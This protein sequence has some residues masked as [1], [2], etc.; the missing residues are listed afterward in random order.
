MPFYKKIKKISLRIAVLLTALLLYLQALTLPTLAEEGSTPSLSAGSAILIEAESGKV[1]FEK[2]AD[3]VRPMASTTKIMTALVALES[4]DVQRTV[5]VSAEAIGIEGSS[6]YLYKDE[7]LTLE[8]L[9]YAM[10]LESAND[11]A[12]AIAI[13]VGGSIDEFADMMNKKADE[14]GLE[15]THFENPHGLDC[16]SHYTTARELAKIAHEAM[17]N[18]SFRSIVS[19]FKKTI[20]LNESEGVR[21]LINHNKMLKGYDGAVGIKTG[22]TKKSGRCLVSA[23]ERDGVKFICVTLN[24][25]D[26]WRDHTALLNYGFS[27]YESRILCRKD[28]FK[29][30]Q[31]VI[32][33]LE[34]YVML[35][36]PDDVTVTVPRGCGDIEQE[37]E[38]PRFSYAQI[39]KGNRIGH[40]VYTA[41][42]NEIA[43][44]PIIASYSV[45]RVKYKK[46]LWERITSLFLR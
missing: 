3:E 42:G 24:A 35:E 8:D 26:D 4:G 20:P 38:L 43:R 27:L 22:F 33:G 23:A 18:E 19:T 32:G 12:A 2:N 10:M 31:P 15:N 44:V 5:Q 6:V 16:D 9:L 28:D 21:L 37:I 1:I 11:A 14:L 7:K 36:I 46:T 30:I 40:L 13:E 41:D 17:K 45:D 39:K 25:P 29:Y 34:E